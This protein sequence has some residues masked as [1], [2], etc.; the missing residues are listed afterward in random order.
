MLKTILAAVAAMAVATSANASSSTIGYVQSVFGTYNGAVLFYIVDAS[1]NPI[2]R[3]GVP[4]CGA[5]LNSRWAL[6]AS[7]VAGQASAAVLLSAWSSRT[8]ITV[9]GEGT[10]TIWSDTE[11]VQ[12]FLTEH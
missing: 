1:G 6:D 8:R 9:V 3:T 4:S 11:T 2:T 10:C 5:T 7:T 12:F